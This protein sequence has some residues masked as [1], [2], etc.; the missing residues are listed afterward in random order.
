MKKG[1]ERERRAGGAQRVV[2]DREYDA[3]VGQQM[4]A[5][6]ESS[7]ARHRCRVRPRPL[8]PRSGRVSSARRSLRLPR[9]CVAGTHRRPSDKRRY[10]VL[11]PGRAVVQSGGSVRGRSERPTCARPRRSVGAAGEFVAVGDPAGHRARPVYH[12]HRASAERFGRSRCSLHD[13]HSAGNRLQPRR[14]CAVVSPD[15]PDS[16]ATHEWFTLCRVPR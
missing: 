14:S 2:A 15:P 16:V 1:T 9:G 6:G 5:S 11:F 13:H 8:L 4:I 7:P 3:A 12:H 10:R